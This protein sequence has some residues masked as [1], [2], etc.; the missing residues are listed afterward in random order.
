MNEGQ[1]YKERI[2]EMLEETEDIEILRSIYTV[3]N[4]LLKQNE[5]KCMVWR[6]K[7]KNQ[8]N[9]ESMSEQ[10]KRYIIETIE[11]I[12]DENKL[13][14]LYYF[15]KGF[16]GEGCQKELNAVIRASIRSMVDALLLKQTIK[17]G[18]QNESIV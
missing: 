12:T 9:V 6:F 16:L 8:E 15:I 11:Q 1:N 2:Q 7:M 10:R 17:R 5:S 4:N 14:K 13:G 3:L 18:K